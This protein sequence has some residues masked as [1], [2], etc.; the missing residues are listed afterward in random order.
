MVDFL[1][2]MRKMALATAITGFAGTAVAQTADVKPL[3]STVNGMHI[4]DR[5]LVLPVG[6]TEIVALPPDLQTATLSLPDVL[7]VNLVS[8]KVAE[9]LAHHEG[10]TDVLFTGKD[11]I[12][13]FHV[14]VMKRPVR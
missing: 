12:Y 10:Q 5:T 9:I 14:T 3:Q 13:R 7:H 6:G 2:N 8:Q 11:T 1:K 4:I